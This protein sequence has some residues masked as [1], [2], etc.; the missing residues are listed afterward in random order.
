MSELERSCKSA[1]YAFEGSNPSL[2]TLLKASAQLDWV[3]AFKR[4]VEEGRMRS[5]R[6]D[7]KRSEESEFLRMGRHGLQ[8]CDPKY[9]N[10]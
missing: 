1:G 4:T 7:P 3:E 2:P 5:F 6:C 10:C 8:L 9:P